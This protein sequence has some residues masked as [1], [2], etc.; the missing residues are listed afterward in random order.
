MNA[1]TY[2]DKLLRSRRSCRKFTSEVPPA[3]LV[4]K[5]VMAGLLAPTGRGRQSSVIVRIDDPDL[6]ARITAVNAKI[7]GAPPS[8]DR[9]PDP[10]YAA[11]VM[12]LVIANKS[13]NTA[14][15]DGSLALGNMMLKAE[16]LCLASCWIHRA[17][18]EMEGELGKEI[19]ERL[20]LEGEWE[21]V[22][23]L[24]LG[25]AAVPPPPQK[26]LRPGRYLSL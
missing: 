12:L 6:K 5:V 11:P 24:A 13:N 1:E 7:M 18:E 23:H 25:Y 17:K 9:G 21:G 14:V 16:E 22:G 2:Y 19:L 15:Y 10:F 20:G 26:P 3:E 4:D 8:P